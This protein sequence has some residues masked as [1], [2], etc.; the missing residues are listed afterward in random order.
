MFAQPKLT[1]CVPSR[2]RQPYFQ[3]TIRSLLANMRMDVEY[4]FADNSD[5]ASIMND[6]MKDVLADPR[7]KYLPS[8]GRV[9]PMV[10]NWDRCVEATT[11]EFVCMIG[12]DDYVDV[13]VA[14]LI[15]RCQAEQSTLDVLIW[16]RLTFNW[17]CNRPQHCNIAAHLDTGVYRISRA[18]AYQEF[19][20]WRGGKASP[21]MAFGFYHGAV[22]MRVMNKIKAKFGGKY[23]EYPVVDFENIC[24]VLVTAEQMVY[25]GRSFSVLGSC[26]KSNSAK[27]K[28]TDKLKEQLAAFMIET[29][30]N[31]DEDAHMKDF[32]FRST[33][34]LTAVIAQTQHWFLAQYGYS[35][36]T[37]WEANFAEACGNSCSIMS[38]QEDRDRAVEG[39][40]QAFANWKGGKYLK[41][42]Q[43]ADFPDAAGGHFF[44]GVSDNQLYIDEEIGGVQTP[45]E[46]YDFVDQML[47]PQ[48]DLTLNFNEYFKVA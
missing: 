7:V 25:S 44:T 14:D 6:F 18:L 33:L 31:I 22:S 41:H 17:P 8:V 12:D 46:L 47:A 13:D 1:I 27:I 48:Q 32:P 40:R 2:N 21:N 15:R 42:F 5:D 9:L 35:P 28:T 39:F 4:I 11:G 29:Q 20:G 26:A 37:G 10:E 45:A 23:C 19:F 24:K 38:T 36:M 3:E 43:P 30:R 34:G 16:N